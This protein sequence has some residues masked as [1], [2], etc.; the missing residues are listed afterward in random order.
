MFMQEFGDFIN[1]ALSGFSFI[2]SCVDFSFKFHYSCNYIIYNNQNKK[3]VQ[4]LNTLKR[5]VENL[6]CFWQTR[7]I[8]ASKTWN[9]NHYI[10]L[11]GVSYHEILNEI[12]RYCPCNGSD[13]YQPGKIPLQCLNCRKCPY[14]SR[15]CTPAYVKTKK[16][17]NLWPV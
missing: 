8:F 3:Y 5:A 12:K 11:Q 6:G 1:L 14:K 2:H 9:Q 4:F 17:R 15:L 10:I 7:N 13:C 16:K